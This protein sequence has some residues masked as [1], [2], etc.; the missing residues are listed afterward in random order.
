MTDTQAARLVG[1]KR[2]AAHLGVSERS[3][4]RWEATEALPVHRQQHD[5]R[6]TV[7]AYADELDRW[8]E[9]RAPGEESG[10]PAGSTFGRRSVLVAALLLLAIVFVLGALT[11]VPR[12]QA[13]LS[14]DRE[15]VDLFE[16]GTALYAQ[17]GREP[18]S[19]SIKL[20]TQAVERD[21][22]F[23]EAWAGLA[24]SWAV[25][26]AYD[27]AI[28]EDR[29]TAESVSAANRALT[30]K[31]D[32]ADIRTL[33]VSAA[34]RKRDW[35]EAAIAAARDAE[36]ALVFVGPGSTAET[37]GMDR[38]SM[39]LPNEQ[40]AL[41]EAVVAANANTVVCVNSGGPV[42]MPWAGKVKAIV[43]CWLPGQEGGHALAD[44]LTGTVNPSAKLPVTFPRRYEDN[45]TFLHYPGGSHVHYSE[46][47]FVGYRHYDALGIAPLFPFGHGLSYTSFALSDLEAPEGA[48][49]GEDISVTCTLDNTG[50]RAGAEVVQLYLEH[51]DPAETMPPRQLK[52]FAKHELAPGETTK[53]TLKVPGR[54]F[55]WYDVD[56][57]AWTV[58][59]G[60]YRLHVGTSSRNLPI[61]HDI[62][63]GA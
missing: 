42:E 1:W 49:A 4:R 31:P 27:P 7:F 60:R 55:A 23:A 46:G 47:L 14:A 62:E 2:I 59:P 18:V 33:L 53:V 52:A 11:M 20:F 54:A 40:N 6:S 39:R 12:A 9:S 45:P 51:C 56:A 37:E 38:A 36:V 24:R 35:A 58:T 19:R 50:A 26:P 34:Y 10:G 8:V 57:D 13:D 16:R 21:E 15:A 29:A 25:Y 17:R 48:K 41:V 32:L 3:A 30:L 44:V 43:Q 22:N 28:S 5:A 61:V 63:I